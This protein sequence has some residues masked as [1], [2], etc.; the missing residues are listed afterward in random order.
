MPTESFRPVR[1]WHGKLR[2]CHIHRVQETNDASAVSQVLLNTLLREEQAHQGTAPSTLTD[3]QAEDDRPKPCVPQSEQIRQD[4][5][6]AAKRSMPEEQ[7]A[8]E[9]SGKGGGKQT[10][11]TL[12]IEWDFSQHVKYPVMR[13]RQVGKP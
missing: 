9:S 10:A 1:V 6:A 13:M 5:S 3:G 11:K 2:S 7:A 4:S 12:K 8:G